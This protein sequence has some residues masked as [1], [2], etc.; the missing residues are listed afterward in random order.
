MSDRSCALEIDLAKAFRLVHIDPA[1]YFRRV[2]SLYA[3]EPTRFHELP[4]SRNGFCVE[5]GHPDFFIRR[6][7]AVIQRCVLRCDAY[8]ASSAVA[9][10]RLDTAKR[11]HHSSCTVT[12]G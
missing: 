2:N 1:K 5:I 11:H 4:G 9:Y 12:S 8:R 7:K 10:H 3:V 6:V